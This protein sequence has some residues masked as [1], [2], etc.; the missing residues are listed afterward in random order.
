M[1]YK[2]AIEP[3]IIQSGYKPIRNIDDSGPNWFH[4]M[5]RNL[6]TCEM[7]VVDLTGSRFNCIWE[8]GILNALDIPVVI[9]CLDDESLPA[10]IFS[11][12]VTVFYNAND[13]KTRYKKIIVNLSKKI[14]GV[15]SHPQ[16]GKFLPKL[17]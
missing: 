6:H 8:L 16:K 11:Q 13:N 15:M 4:D 2:S 5:A 10:D 1:R 3:G 7:A 12:R 17:G 9:I 14:K